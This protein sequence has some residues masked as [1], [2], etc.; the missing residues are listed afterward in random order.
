MLASTHQTTLLYCM[1]CANLVS[2]S[3]LLSLRVQVTIVLAIGTTVMAHNNAIIRQLPA[4]ETLGS[5][6]IICSDKTGTLTK[7]GAWCVCGLRM[8]RPCALQSGACLS[9]AVGWT[10]SWQ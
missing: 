3:R 8:G 2:C 9:Q 4:V 1:G 5:L 7:N 6:T 10:H